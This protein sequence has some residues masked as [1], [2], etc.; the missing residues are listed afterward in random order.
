VIVLLEPLG[1]HDCAITLGDHIPFPALMQ[2]DSELGLALDDL[3]RWD[4]LL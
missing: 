1:E 4:I 3:P 2:I